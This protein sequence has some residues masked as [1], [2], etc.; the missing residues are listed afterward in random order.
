MEEGLEQDDEDRNALNRAVLDRMMEM[1]RAAQVDCASQ[2]EDPAKE[3]E[4]LTLKRKLRVKK[5]KLI[6]SQSTT[7]VAESGLNRPVL[8][9]HSLPNL[10]H[11]NPYKL[12]RYLNLINHISAFIRL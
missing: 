9:A 1:Q 3:A 10:S 6:T 7:D 2:C 11:T 8:P 5:R 4:L 12:N